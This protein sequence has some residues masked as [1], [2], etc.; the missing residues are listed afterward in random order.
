MQLYQS[1]PMESMASYSPKGAKAKI[2][3]ALKTPNECAT[4]HSELAFE[5]W[6]KHSYLQLSCATSQRHF[7]WRHMSNVPPRLCEALPFEILLSMCPVCGSEG[8]SWLGECMGQ[9][10]FRCRD[11]GFE[12]SLFDH[13]DLAEPLDSDFQFAHCWEDD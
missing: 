11:C 5:E 13:Q 12:Y 2:Q 1:V 4:L 8:T 7:R 6:I 9:H 10:W 3:W